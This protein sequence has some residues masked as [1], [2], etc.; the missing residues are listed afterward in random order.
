MVLLYLFNRNKYRP[1]NGIELDEN[2]L[3]WKTIYPENYQPKNDENNLF[4]TAVL[5][6]KNWDKIQYEIDSNFVFLINI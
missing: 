3:K 6:A 5:A 1:F 2:K 4:D